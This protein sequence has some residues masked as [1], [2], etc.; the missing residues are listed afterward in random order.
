MS[1]WGDEPVSPKQPQESTKKQPISRNNG[2]DDTWTSGWGNTGGGMASNVWSNPRPQRNGYHNSR[3]P[4]TQNGFQNFKKC[5]N[6]GG[7]GHMARECS[8]SI[9]PRSNGFGNGFNDQRGDNN[10]GGPV[11][12]KCGQAGHVVRSCPQNDVDVWG[13]G[14]A[15]S[16]PNNA[17]ARSNGGGGDFGRPSPSG[18]RDYQGGGGRNN[19]GGRDNYGGHDNNGVG[20]N[21]YSSNNGFHQHRGQGC[22]KC[23]DEGHWS[24]ECPQERPEDQNAGGSELPPREKYIPPEILDESLFDHGISSGI[25]FEKYNDTPG[26]VTGNDPPNSIKSFE[27]CNLRSLLMENIRKSKYT[28]P[29][30]VQR[31]ALPIIMAGRDMMACAQTGSGKT[32]AFLLPMLHQ[33]LADGTEPHM[34]H[35]QS[36][37]VVILTPTRELAIQITKEA[38]KF[39]YKCNLGVMALYGGTDIGYQFDML[40]ER[41][42]NILV[43]TPGRLLHSVKENVV[44]FR[45]VKFFVLDEADRMLDM[46]FMSDIDELVRNPMM[47]P[48]GKRQTLMFSA[49]FPDDVQR[50]AFTYLQD[51]LFLKV[52]IVGGACSDVTQMFFEIDQ[53]EKRE[54]LVGILKESQRA[55]GETEKTLVFV[56]K[57]QAA[58]FLASF[59]SQDDVSILGSSLVR[60]EFGS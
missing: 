6:C 42:V 57:K 45:N 17:W 7:V 49:T 5:T 54:K 60:I 16:R 29:T 32:A 31:H 24:K 51:Y 1:D 48:K 18:G 4:P 46:G 44:T 8:S 52:G 11:C 3:P 39:A 26:V 43:A 27:E 25:N 13:G 14:A 2:G 22:F 55:P 50:A 15:S 53:Y 9:P 59:L 30:P 33:L 10:G 56:E 21:Q 20:R 40:R 36:P 28:N 47:P 58:D 37:E 34:G 23:G 38:K 41:N 35:P 12:Y 19:Y